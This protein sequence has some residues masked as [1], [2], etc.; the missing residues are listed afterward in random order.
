MIKDVYTECPS[1]ESERF[2]IRFC[3]PSDAVDLFEVYS[4]K[5]AVPFFNSDNCGGDDFYYKTV[6]RMHQAVEYWIWEYSRKGFVRWTILDKVS[7]KSVGTI[8]LFNRKA[9]DFFS[10]CGILR[11]DLRSDYEKSE[12]IFEILGLI[13]PPSFDLFKCRMI[14]TKAFP[15]AYERKKAMDKYGF[16]ETENKLIG[17]HDGIAYENYCI[18]YK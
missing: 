10:N 13:V 14:A 17:T 16:S 8:E 2:L 5:K 1:Y 15:T 4:D 9:D 7:K 18:I 3:E 6:D 12:L 11:L